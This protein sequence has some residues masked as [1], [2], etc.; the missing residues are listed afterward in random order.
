[1][2]CSLAVGRVGSDVAGFRAGRRRRLSEDIVVEE[3]AMSA[4]V[5]CLVSVGMELEVV[6][7]GIVVEEAVGIGSF[8]LAL[9]AGV[10]RRLMLA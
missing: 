8:A 7:A 10:G 5:P 4:P 6:A 9:F 3:A 2:A 1:V